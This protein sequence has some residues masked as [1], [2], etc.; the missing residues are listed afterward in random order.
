M[1]SI[2]SFQSPIALTF[3]SFAFTDI[4]GDFNERRGGTG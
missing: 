1:K 3:E 2:K 4:A